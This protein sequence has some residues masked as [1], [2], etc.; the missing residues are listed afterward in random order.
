MMSMEMSEN[1]LVEIDKKVSKSTGLHLSG[2]EMTILLRKLLFPIC[3]IM[4]ILMGCD[5]AHEKAKKESIATL[6]AFFNEMD[7]DEL[8]ID[9]TDLEEVMEAIDEQ[10]GEYLTGD[11]SRKI[12]NDIRQ[13]TRFQEDFAKHPKTFTFFLT[14]AGGG[15][16]FAKGEVSSHRLW[17]TLDDEIVG[18][19]IRV[20]LNTDIPEWPHSWAESAT[21]TMMKLDGKWKIDEVSYSS[22]ILES[23]INVERLKLMSHQIINKQ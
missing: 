2:K 5:D 12:E 3:L 6:E 4:F 17:L 22:G 14:N 8:I 19:E 18:T 10:L 9:S 13:Y 20:K 1:C 16:Q 23:S 21:V 15:F 11:F 7:H